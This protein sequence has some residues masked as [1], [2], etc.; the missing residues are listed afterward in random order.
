MGAEAMIVCCVTPDLSAN[1]KSLTMSTL[2]NAFERTSP[3][4]PNSGLPC[5][6]VDRCF[7]DHGSLIIFRQTGTRL[8]EAN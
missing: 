8:G 5:P 6:F 2:S 7:D 4:T 1:R 3:F